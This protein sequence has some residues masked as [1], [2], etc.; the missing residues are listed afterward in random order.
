MLTNGPFYRPSILYFRIIEESP[1]PIVYLKV[2]GIITTLHF[3]QIRYGV[4]Q[5][6]K[7]D[8]NKN[9]KTVNIVIKFEFATKS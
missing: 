7:I 2:I 1:E 8:G 4:R 6:E 9:I 5:I 3:T